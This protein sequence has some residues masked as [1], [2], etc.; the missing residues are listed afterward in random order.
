[1]KA[2]QVS[3]YLQ[4]PDLDYGIFLLFGPN[5][6]L[7][8]ENSQRLI[9]YYKNLYANSINEITLEAAQIIENSS[10]LEVEARNLPMFADL[11]LIR[12]RGVNN[13]L[14]PIIK[15]LI[16][17]MPK[18]IIILEAA[19]LK[20]SDNLVKI[21]EKHDLART[22]PCYQDDE[23]AITDIILQNFANENIVIDNDAIAILR[24][25]LG[26]DRE[27]IRREL[28]KL[29]IFAQETKS[30]SATDVIL[31]CGDNANITIDKINDFLGTAHVEKLDRELAKALNNNL[32]DAQ[33]ILISALNH[34][35]FLRLLR[36]EFDKGVSAR[37]IIDK[38][39]PPIHF[40]RKKSLEQQLRLWSDERLRLASE[41]IYQA[42]YESRKTPTLAPAITKRSLMAISLA[43]SKY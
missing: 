36:I 34:F 10:I 27:L 32:L 2:Y 9:N 6:G 37:A 28:E 3:K 19:K 40:S 5:N 24:N 26:N 29:N 30:I 13:R 33:R 7:I 42:I 8:F 38:Q 35:S 39:R 17:D 20:L 41:R 43:A 31:L 25:I 16:E 18:S 4:K 15:K 22:L 14:S 1:M 23:R 12:V 21:L 11:V